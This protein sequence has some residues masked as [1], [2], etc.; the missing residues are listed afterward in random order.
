MDLDDFADEAFVQSEW[1]TWWDSIRDSA[2][3]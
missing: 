2:G 3:R 1:A